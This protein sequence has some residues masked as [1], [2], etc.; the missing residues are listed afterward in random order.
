MIAPP[1]TNPK[2]PA[3][4]S[5]AIEEGE[6]IP[7]SIAKSLPGVI[8]FGIVTAG[9]IAVVILP[10]FAS[11]DWR[12]ALA[13]IGGIALGTIGWWGLRAWGQPLLHRDHLILGKTYLQLIRGTQPVL[14]GQVPYLNMATVV[15]LRG[16][17]GL[18]SLNDPRTFWP[19]CTRAELES[20]RAAGDLDLY[21]ENF[22]QSA[23]LI[24]KKVRVQRDRL[25]SQEY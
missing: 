10:L 22:A 14:V 15:P 1:D 7:I 23:E 3:D 9:A 24:L 8:I 5:F 18:A 17:I 4:Y 16:G 25:R 13:Q 20:R 2:L 21:I 12:T 11:W 19:E 6:R